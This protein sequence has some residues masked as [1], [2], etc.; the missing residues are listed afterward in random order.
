MAKVKLIATRKM[1]YNTRHLEAGARFE[2][3]P[4]D[5]VVLTELRKSARYDYEAPVTDPL[6]QPEVSD[7]V[8][9]ALT[10]VQLRQEAESLGIRLDRRWAEGRLRQE[11][12]RAR[13]GPTTAAAEPEPAPTP[14]QEPEAEPAPAPEPEP[15]RTPEPDWRP[16]AQP[17]PAEVEEQAAPRTVGMV[18]TLANFGTEPQR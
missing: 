8:A 9:A 11:I 10:L 1:M 15:E 3:K 5:A 2:A 14:V 17:S 13:A 12:D 7:Q 16:P 6:P 4:I 18:H